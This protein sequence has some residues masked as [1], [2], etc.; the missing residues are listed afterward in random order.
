[1]SEAYW[2]AAMTA[3]AMQA[4]AD[5]DRRFA[6]LYPNAGPVLESLRPAAEAIQRRVQESETRRPLYL[7][8]PIG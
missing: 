2:R 7:S 8:L 6:E 3:L 1:M 4:F 5:I